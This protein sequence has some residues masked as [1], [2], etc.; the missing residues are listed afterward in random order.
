MPV[1]P[2]DPRVEVRGR[3]MAGYSPKAGRC[4]W[5]RRPCA[6]AGRPGVRQ[7]VGSRLSRCLCS[8]TAAGLCKPSRLSSSRDR[9]GPACTA[10]QRRRPTT[11]PLAAR[12]CA[13]A[14]ARRVANPLWS[15]AVENANQIECTIHRVSSRRVQ[16]CSCPGHVLMNVRQAHGPCVPVISCHKGPVGGAD[17]QHDRLVCREGFAVIRTEPIR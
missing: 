9:P 2:A 14:V 11:K 7:N 10:V 8:V 6:A 16:R 5:W 4:L 15:P 17:H 13:R 12:R 1:N 3:Q